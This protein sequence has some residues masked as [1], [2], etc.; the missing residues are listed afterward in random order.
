MLQFFHFRADLL[1]VVVLIEFKVAIK[2][3]VM[4]R[5]Q[6]DE[7][8]LLKLFKFAVSLLSNLRMHFQ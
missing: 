8:K 1:L 5:D 4:A 2:L 7:L 3:L 6:V